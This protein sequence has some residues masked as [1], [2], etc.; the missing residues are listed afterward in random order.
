MRLAI[1]INYVHTINIDYALSGH[2]NITCIHKIYVY[3]FTKGFYSL[4]V[5]S[6]LYD[7]CDTV[8]IKVTLHLHV[9]YMQVQPL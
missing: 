4:F 9:P 1:S 3:Y 2:Y 5:L 6:A 7:N 8:L